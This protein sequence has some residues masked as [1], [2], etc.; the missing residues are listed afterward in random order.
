MKSLELF[1]GVLS[2]DTKSDMFISDEGIIIESGA[3][4]AKDLI[5][6]YFKDL[7]LSGNDLNKT[8]HKSWS[9]IK[10]SD[11]FE[12]FVEQIKH[13]I[14][15]YG[16]DFT[17][18][19]YIPDE[20][21]NLPDVKLKYK[22]I[23]AYTKEELINKCFNLLNSGIAMKEETINDILVCLHDELGYSF[24]GQEVIKNKEAIIILAD[25]Y[26][27]LPTDTMELFRYIIYRTT[28]N[29]LLIKNDDM[30]KAIVDS[31]FNPSVLFNRHGLE[32][33]ATIFNRFK[34]L[35]LAYKNKCPRIINKISKLSKTYH[36]P[37]VQNPL[38]YVTSIPL[39]ETDN[40]WLD[41][42]TIYALFKTLNACKTR[43]NGQDTFTY[44]VRNGKSFT[45]HKTPTTTPYNTSIIE[46]YMIDKYKLDGI[47]VYLPKDIVYALPTSEK[48]M[49]GNVPTGT[50]CYG[51]T[52]AIGV[53]WQNN[54]G[55]RDLDI[56][57]INLYGKTGWNSRYN[58]NNNLYY[59]G[60]ITN[61]PNGAVEYIYANK[62]LSIPTLI[63]NNVFTGDN[64]CQYKIIVGKGSDIN[65]DYMMN[66]NKLFM[67]IKCQSIQ[68]Q[69][70]LG[71]LLPDDDR[72]CF[73]LLNF[74][75][76]NLRVSGNS[77]ISMMNVDALTQQYRYNYSFNDLIVKLGA[78]LVDKAEDAD[79]DFSI[80]NL[81]KTSFIDIF[82]RKEK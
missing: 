13:Y 24:T 55:A 47:K 40:H 32:K 81:T 77:D 73:I 33:M 46:D 50:K 18:E 28:N 69:T 10:N 26:N 23:K 53:Y 8:F 68:K 5:I 43:L 44:R 74:G 65:K 54:W 11:R 76:G 70:V 3:M 7:K 71:L 56:S 38:N 57:A 6:E 9:T 22:V 12:L 82:N 29:S 45:K 59:S 19:V 75:A 31:S 2:K 34:P 39:K 79:Y 51:D 4:W 61:A 52:L 37:L 58:Q 48:M 27:V 62:G 64:D 66:P 30:I 60:D 63:Q 42:A 20:I 80:H 14:S 16:S 1:N 21:L 49:V 67:D 36:K 41:N 25:M 17:D 78:T 35:F 15:T 72:Q